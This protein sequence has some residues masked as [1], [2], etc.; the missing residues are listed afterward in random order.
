MEK[1]RWRV[2][3]RADWSGV[4]REEWRGEIV[5]GDINSRECQVAN[6]LRVEVVH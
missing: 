4:E 3:D 2:V 6:G 5:R 1:N